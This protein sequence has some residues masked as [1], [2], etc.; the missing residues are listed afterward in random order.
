[1]SNTW[2]GTF[3]NEPVLSSPYQASNGK[4]GVIEM[5][6]LGD[7]IVNAPIE[8]ENATFSVSVSNPTRN[9]MTINAPLI[10]TP[11]GTLTSTVL[12]RGLHFVIG[13]TNFTGV[14]H[15]S[16]YVPFV[17]PLG[18]KIAAQWIPRDTNG[19]CTLTD[20]HH[21]TSVTR[22]GEGLYS[23]TT[24]GEVIGIQDLIQ[25]QAFALGLATENTPEINTISQ[26]PTVLNIETGVRS[27][28]GNWTDSDLTQD[29]ANRVLF[30]VS[31]L[32]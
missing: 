2:S 30:I 1:M 17:S 19:L 13:F 7:L 32:P 31:H 22:T 14:W 27:K 9:L 21:V 12:L 4:R 18:V 29:P 16:D 25:Y 28:V 15:V 20:N 10:E 5:D 11:D 24:D 26:S 3:Q 6:V 23:I 8:R